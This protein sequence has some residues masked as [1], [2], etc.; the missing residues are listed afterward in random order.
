MLDDSIASVD[1]GNI[2]K[3]LNC[4]DLSPTDFMDVKCPIL[5]D[6]ILLK[7]NQVIYDELELSWFTKESQLVSQPV[8]FSLTIENSHIHGNNVLYLA[9]TTLP[10][11]LTLPSSSRNKDF[12]DMDLLLLEKNIL[13]FDNS[14]ETGNDTFPAVGNVSLSVSL[15]LAKPK[16]FFSKSSKS[17]S[18]KSLYRDED[19][20]VND[21]ED[22]VYEMTSFPAKKYNDMYYF[23]L[24]A[25]HGLKPGDYILTVTTSTPHLGKTGSSG[26]VHSPVKA[27][28]PNQ[29]L[30]AN[31]NRFDETS[32]ISTPVALQ[33]FKVSYS[34]HPLLNPLSIDCLTATRGNTIQPDSVIYYRYNSI[35]YNSWVI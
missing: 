25:A 8:K 13:G 6:S 31:K 35:N 26:I 24:T 18:K 17:M 30:S 20:R 11:S 5:K 32:S 10:L 3:Y 34:I 9:I 19:G 21:A 14:R 1:N 4:N 12:F 2:P 15:E 27:S 7:C 16:M 29:L 22:D 28:Y 23:V 33:P